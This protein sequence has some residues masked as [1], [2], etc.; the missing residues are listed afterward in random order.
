MDYG[1]VVALV[2]GALSVPY[3]IWDTIRR[4][5]KFDKENTK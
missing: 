4:V 5:D 1:L 3:F 2:A